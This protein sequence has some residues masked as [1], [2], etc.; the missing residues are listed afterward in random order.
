MCGRCNGDPGCVL[1]L[2]HLRHRR[3][4]H[5]MTISDNSLAIVNLRMSTSM[6]SLLCLRGN[7]RNHDV[8]VPIHHRVDPSC[9]SIANQLG[10]LHGNQL[11]Q[12]DA[13]SLAVNVYCFFLKFVLVPGSMFM[14][15]FDNSYVY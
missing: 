2:L 7:L 12:S 11:L 8:Q 10:P 6:T 3:K 13:G 14:K 5:E 4:V 1:P 9:F 15:L